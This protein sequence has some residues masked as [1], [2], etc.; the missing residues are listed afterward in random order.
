MKIIL[1]EEGYEE[2]AYRKAYSA[3]LRDKKR[4]EWMLR[5]IENEQSLER[6]VQLAKV[7]AS[8][9]VH[10]NP[11]YF[12][13]TV[14][15]E[16]FIEYAQ[17]H[18]ITSYNITYQKNSFLHVM[19]QAYVTG[20]HTRVVERW[21]DVSPETQI[22]SV[23]ILN[24]KDVT[25]PKRLEEVIK[26]KNGTLTLFDKKLSDLN[27]ALKLREIGL[28]YQYI[29]LHVHMDDPTAL[30]AFGTEKFTR[31]IIYYNHADHLF[32]LGGSIADKFADLR[33]ITSITRTRKL[34]KEPYML[35]VPMENKTMATITKDSARKKLGI[36]LERKLI[37]TGGSPQ[38]YHTLMG[39]SLIPILENKVNSAENLYCIAIGPT[40]TGDWKKVNVS[41]NGKIKAIGTVPYAEGFLDYLA[42]ADVVVDSWPMSGG[43]FL[44]DAISLKKTVIS[45]AN[46]MGQ[47]DY[48]TKS[49][50]YCKNISDFSEK[51]DKILSNEE[52]ANQLLEE[53]TTNLNNDHCDQRWMKKLQK[54]I[55][56]T[57]AH[58]QVNHLQTADNSPTIDEWVIAA[59]R[60]YTSITKYLYILKYFLLKIG[61][62]NE[63]ID[64][65]YNQCI[66]IAKKIY[67]SIR[68]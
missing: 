33:T 16:T 11:G 43:T 2:K 20:G 60:L 12:T 42:A 13:S 15:E 58:H 26:N 1:N 5:G 38:K 9:A 67:N 34:I 61:F 57:P 59:N 23:I 21:I 4:F 41:T 53:I 8:F 32:S 3:V 54:L 36:P 37:I 56:E 29:I 45:L 64:R 63:L 44:I 17:Q 51:I 65:I 66:K 62:P 30:I 22:H 14:L 7:A 25:V 28:H 10:N 6:K 35:G 49:Q 40:N 27:R 46:P 31:P 52:Y 68:Q 24:Q 39:R 47:F 19:T 48:I 50:S 55:N 18:D